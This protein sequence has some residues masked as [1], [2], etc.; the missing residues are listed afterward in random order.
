[1][2]NCWNSSLSLQSATRYENPYSNLHNIT[3]YSC[4]FVKLCQNGLVSKDQNYGTL[5]LY[6]AI[7][8]GPDFLQGVSC[9]HE[10][11][12][13]VWTAWDSCWQVNLSFLSLPIPGLPWSGLSL[14][15]SVTN[16]SIYLTFQEQLTYIQL[17]LYNLKSKN[18]WTLS[19]RNFIYPRNCVN[20]FNNDV[21]WQ[22]SRTPIWSLFALLGIDITAKSK[23][24]TST[25]G[26]YFV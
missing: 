14:N 9:S 3:T 2:L 26:K 18:K 13:L 8:F 16:G 12:Q 24:S 25:D 20:Y 7:I 4:I 19:S 21:I 11:V 15:K 5:M 22:S 17:V 23:R 10:H 1:M 6:K